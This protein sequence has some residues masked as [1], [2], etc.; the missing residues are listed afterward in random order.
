MFF[1]FCVLLLI[2]LGCNK[3]YDLESC[4]ELS[5]K[6]FKGFT[7][8]KE[9]FSK[10]CMNFEVKYTPELCQSALTDLILNN[11]LTEI[12]RKYGDP[13]ESCFTP[14]DLKKHNVPK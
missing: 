2:F 6:K 12:K 14:E 8:A 10:N 1:R 3:K 4:N 11:D 9:K 7:D 5:M 13:I